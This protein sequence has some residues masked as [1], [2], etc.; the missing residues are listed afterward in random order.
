MRSAICL[1]GLARTYKQTWATLMMNVVD[2]LRARGQVDIFISIWD[3]MDM[4]AL[5]PG[6]L[7]REDMVDL[8]GLAQ[9]YQPTTLEVERL[10]SVMGAF[11]LAR[12]TDKPCPVPEIVKGGVLLSVPAQYRVARCNDL[13][14]IHER[15]HGFQY[16]LVVRTRLDFALSPLRIDELDLTKVNVLYDQD[17]L[18]GDYLYIANSPTMDRVASLCHHYVELLNLPNTDMGPERNLK[19]HLVAEGLNTSIMKGYSYALVREDSLQAFHW[20]DERGGY[21]PYDIQQ[22]RYS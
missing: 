12:F 16:D 18:V 1:S 2:P 4:A 9:A 8:T 15:L 14:C 13:K 5:S 3:S 20:D 19:N 21:R 10:A 22:G 17:G 7:V 6:R 11:Q